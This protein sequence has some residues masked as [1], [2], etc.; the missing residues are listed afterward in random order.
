MPPTIR[1]GRPDDIGAVLGLWI[2]GGAEP[3]RTDDADSLR[4]LLGHPGSALL[5]AGEGSALVGSVVVG[6]DGWRGS[7]YRLVV[8]PAH[9]HQGLGRRLLAAAEDHLS[10]VG[11]VRL[12]AVVVDTEPLATGFW[13]ATEWEEQDHRLRFV[14]G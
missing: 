8:D 9:R 13:R 3:T 6:W 4:A 5:V 1:V 2:R 14:R 7:V 12:Q 10:A 11:A